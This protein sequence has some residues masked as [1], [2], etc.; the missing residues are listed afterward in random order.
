MLRW[1]CSEIRKT[2]PKDF[3]PDDL[4]VDMGQGAIEMNID[5]PKK[6]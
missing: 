6:Q 2:S 4:V 5:V 1:S 3:K